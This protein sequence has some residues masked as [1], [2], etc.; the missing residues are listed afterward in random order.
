MGANLREILALL[1]EISVRNMDFSTSSIE[2]SVSVCTNYNSKW[3]GASSLPTY[4]VHLPKQRE[5][6]TL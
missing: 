2:V 3:A 1:L 6:L 4:I 5:F